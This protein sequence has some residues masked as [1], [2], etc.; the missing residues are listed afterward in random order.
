MEFISFNL[1]FL[2]YIHFKLLKNKQISI[3]HQPTG[4]YFKFPT[5]G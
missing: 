5:F 3:A 1:I 4:N 2:I